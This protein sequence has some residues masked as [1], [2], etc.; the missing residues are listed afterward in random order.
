[1]TD[2]VIRPLE[3]PDIAAFR[4]LLL[5]WDDGDAIVAEPEL[6]EQIERARRDAGGEVLLAFASDG[7]LAGYA[8][9][10][11]HVM[12]GMGT[13]MEVIALLVRD[14][15]RGKRVG[16]ALLGRCEGWAL[17]RGCKLLMLSSQLFR[18]RAHAFY[19]RQGFREVKRS[20]FFIK[21]L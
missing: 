2:L 5:Q 15:L 11:M 4:E 14:D 18:E 16:A 13:A 12:V 21:D 7:S 8:Q 19:R 10:G 3:D 6:A 20:A 17:M 1:M 9:L